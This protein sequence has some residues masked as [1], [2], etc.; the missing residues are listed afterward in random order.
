MAFSTASWIGISIA[1]PLNFLQRIK[2]EVFLNYRKTSRSQ[3]GTDYCFA[4]GLLFNKLFTPLF[5][6]ISKA[7][8]I[9]TGTHISRVNA[10]ISFFNSS[11]RQHSSALINDLVVII[12]R[13]VN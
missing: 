9:N 13:A 8:D 4:N 7:N 5:I 1:S 12:A 3:K 6:T 11:F 10:A 2:K